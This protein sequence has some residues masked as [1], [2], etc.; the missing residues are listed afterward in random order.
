MAK[1]LEELASTRRE[2]EQTAEVCRLEAADGVGGGGEGVGG[3]GEGVGGG[4]K[5]WEVMRGGG[6]NSGVDDGGR[7]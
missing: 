7:P 2:M 6:G 1:V 3:G 5:V 4:G